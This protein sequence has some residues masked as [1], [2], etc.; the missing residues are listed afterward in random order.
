MTTTLPFRV[1]ES[2]T[3]SGRYLV[4]TQDI[5]EDELILTDEA[6]V[7]GPFT[8]SVP[9]CLA[10]NRSLVGQDSPW[11]SHGCGFQLC[12]RC[13]ALEGG[14][15]DWHSLECGMIQKSPN[16]TATYTASAGR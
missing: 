12:Q 9:I 6:F 10:C 14:G 5:E 2:S 8:V 3:T 15:Q 13:S 7:V 1:D 4:A 16:V 11:C